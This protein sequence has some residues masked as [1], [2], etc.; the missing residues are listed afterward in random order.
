MRRVRSEAT[1]QYS[2]NQ[3][4]LVLDVDLMTHSPLQL[5]LPRAQLL[6][7]YAFLFGEIVLSRVCEKSRKH[8]R[9]IKFL[10]PRFF[11]QPNFYH[12]S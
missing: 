6:F 5:P 8:G 3:R 1:R 2:A 11:Q 12:L 4:L 10:N 7:V 9:R